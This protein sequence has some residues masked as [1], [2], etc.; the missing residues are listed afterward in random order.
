MKVPGNSLW[1][2]SRNFPLKCKHHGL[3]GAGHG[4]Y[5]PHYMQIRF[6]VK[7]GISLPLPADQLRVNELAGRAAARRCRL[8]QLQ[9]CR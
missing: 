1:K 8:H 3:R 4:A 7:L 9:A 2:S 5:N 6:F